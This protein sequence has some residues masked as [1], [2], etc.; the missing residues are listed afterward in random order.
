MYSVCSFR[1]TLANLFYAFLSFKALI[2]V[3]L[4]LLHLEVIFMF[5]CFFLI[6]N[7]SHGTQGLALLVGMHFATAS[8]WALRKFSYSSFGVGV[9]NIS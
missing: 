3:G 4:L 5:A 1:Y 8:M 6:A 9:S 7:V 2:M